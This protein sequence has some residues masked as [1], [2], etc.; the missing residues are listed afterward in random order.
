MTKSPESKGKKKKQPGR[1]SLPSRTSCRTGEDGL[2]RPHGHS[3]TRHL[4]GSSAEPS[5]DNGH[6]H[7]SVSDVEEG[8][9]H[10]DPCEQTINRYYTSPPS[11]SES[12]NKTSIYPY[13]LRNR[14]VVIDKPPCVEPSEAAPVAVAEL[15]SR[16]MRRNSATSNYLRG[17][18]ITVSNIPGESNLKPMSRRNSF[19][20]ELLKKCAP[21]NENLR[22]NSSG[23]LTKT[24]SNSGPLRSNDIFPL[25][26]RSS[27][28]TH[29]SRRN[30]SVELDKVTSRPYTSG[31]NDC[32]DGSGKQR[33]ILTSLQL[34]ETYRAAAKT[35]GLNHGKQSDVRNSP[36][37]HLEGDHVAVTT[38]PI[39]PSSTIVGVNH[40]HYKIM[41]SQERMR[42]SPVTETDPVQAA[43]EL[44]EKYSKEI[45][46]SKM[47]EE[48]LNLA[49]KSPL[50]KGN[51]IE[52][53]S[54]LDGR[55]ASHKNRRDSS[56]TEQLLRNYA[57]QK[58]RSSAHHDHRLHE[59]RYR[60]LSAHS[61]KT[62]PR[63]R[64]LKQQQ[65]LI[66]KIRDE[67]SEGEKR[68]KKLQAS[69]SHSNT[70][71]S[72]SD[73]TSQSASIEQKSIDDLTKRKPDG[74]FVEIDLRDA[75]TVD[76]HLP[77]FIEI[78]EQSKEK[79]RKELDEVSK[80]KSKK[81]K[82]RSNE[83][84]S[85]VEHLYDSVDLD[86]PII[87]FEIP[88]PTGNR[89]K[90]KQKR[91]TIQRG[92][93]KKLTTHNIRKIV[94]LSFVGLVV[95]LSITLLL[96]FLVP[97]GGRKFLDS[98]FL[99]GSLLIANDVLYPSKTFTFFSFREINFDT[100][101]QWNT[102]KFGE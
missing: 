26:R 12:K 47:E 56:A 53:T 18:L 43:T 37:H 65:A 16:Q 75:N 2:K 97:R 17:D 61:S 20:S 41:P 45:K 44:I 89:R 27:S 102:P 87:G 11:P 60:R 74:G 22:K 62:D 25:R 78:K 94:M 31:Q 67:V 82:R 54:D 6:R 14:D 9:M 30:S 70:S 95:V 72:Q 64:P 59:G 29:R 40:K 49:R 55:N 88:L 51:S 85:T 57:K 5:S 19:S 34:Q 93:F 46:G 1:V 10:L 76:P 3:E 52:A 73:H 90:E 77:S 39:V 80:N 83:T 66:K 71:D 7:K 38:E 58:R 21:M 50:P 79:G 13:T 48:S 84:K 8:G 15:F 4:T 69:S 99:S 91:M 63:S 98:I 28:T 24:S 92:S 42:S 96:F 35:L 32:W 23:N 101:R 86:D 100:A 33:E 68:N 36:Y 81:S